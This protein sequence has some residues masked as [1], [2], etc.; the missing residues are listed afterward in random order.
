MSQGIIRLKKV[1]VT[2]KRNASI[3]KN[4]GLEKKHSERFEE[5]RPI[6]TIKNLSQDIDL[7]SSDID[8]YFPHKPNQPTPI[9]TKIPENLKNNIKNSDIIPKSSKVLT[10]NNQYIYNKHIHMRSLDQT[11]NDN[12]SNG[13]FINIT[14]RNSLQNNNQI[15]CKEDY[16]GPLASDEIIFPPTMNP[17]EIYGLDMKIVKKGRIFKPQGLE[18]FSDSKP[19]SDKIREKE[20]ESPKI[21]KQ[22]I[23]FRKIIKKHKRKIGKD[24]II[25][26]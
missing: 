21:I 22:T 20:C 26:A 12:S 3:I 19:C 8:S 14:K 16:E 5:Q 10:E 17:N 24:I 25:S 23:P 11:T 15:I 18:R 13:K 2:P 1:K 9:F 6:E 4:K 7:I